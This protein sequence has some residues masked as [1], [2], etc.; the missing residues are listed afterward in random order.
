MKQELNHKNSLLRKARIAVRV[1]VAFLFLLALTWSVNSFFI[2]F[3][4]GLALYAGFLAKHYYDQTEPEEAP[5]GFRES[6]SHEGV[7]QNPA[8]PKTRILI[9]VIAFVGLLIVVVIARVVLSASADQDQA[10]RENS[11]QDKSVP[12]RAVDSL[13]NAGNNLYNGGKYDS[14]LI[15]YNAVLELEQ[16]NQSAQYNKALVLYSTGKYPDA[17]ALV[18]RC[19]HQYP[20]YGDAFWLLGDICSAMNDP[21]SARK[22]F[23]GA[24]E[25]GIRSG[26]FLQTM[27]ASFEAEDKIRAINLYKE[28]LQQDSSLTEAYQKLAELDPANASEYQNMQQRKNN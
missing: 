7:N 28:S 8:T 12:S 24:Y 15:Y 1:A 18:S 19:L 11:P 4:L 14:A 9:F 23:E 13:T 26:S 20:D 5:T 27:A 25:N 16:N 17:R 10:L 21:D 6:D 2:W 22:C 3:F